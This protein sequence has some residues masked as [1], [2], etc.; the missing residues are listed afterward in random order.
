[1]GR[2]AGLQPLVT[3]RSHDG[4][5]HIHLGTDSTI[6]PLVQEHRMLPRTAGAELCSVES[7]VA[8]ILHRGRFFPLMSAHWGRVRQLVTQ[9]GPWLA[10]TC[11]SRQM[12]S[13]DVIWLQVLWT[14]LIEPCCKHTQMFYRSAALHTSPQCSS[15]WFP[16]PLEQGECVLYKTNKQNPQTS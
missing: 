13:P 2:E 8:P 16:Q 7:C 5:V 3:G 12:G 11:A 10:V 6:K 1:M 15:E 4:D 9:Q 14:L